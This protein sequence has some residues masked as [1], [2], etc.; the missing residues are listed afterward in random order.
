M[1]G[2]EEKRIPITCVWELTTKCNL[3]CGHCASSCNE[4]ER[5]E[6]LSEKEMLEVTR[7]IADMGL[8]WVSL[9]GGEVLL[10][11]GWNHVVKCLT[12]RNVRVH[13]IT[14]GTLITEQIAE[15]MKEANLHMVSV[16]L[17]GTKEIHNAIRGEGSY[18]KTCRKLSYVKECGI[19]LGCIT[20]V[21]KENL[22]LLSE[23]KEELIR[24]GIS[25]WQLQLAFPEGNMKVK[26]ESLLEPKDVRTFI[27]LAYELSLDNR[28]RIILPD[29]VGYY[30]WEEQNL[31]SDGTKG[32]TAWQGC[33]AGIRSFGILSN[34]DV[35]G[36]TS[37]RSA[38]FLEGNIRER[39][40]SDIWEDK[41]CF[42]WRRQFS[43]E[44]LQGVCRECRY[45]DICLGGCSNIR[46]T[47]NGTIYSEN[48]YCAYGVEVLSQ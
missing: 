24:I 40:L 12:E 1:R 4:Q 37:I 30:T 38:E 27:N 9:T 15:Q 26:K 8:R 22:S 3:R 21:M 29:N 35:V 42:N 19:T 33:S 14:N 47:V 44:C 41:K 17:D 11:K 23:M 46:Y 45:V 13:L 48:P 43:K 10:K 25:Q 18:E 39:R 16:S 31:R 36:C 5:Q 7:Q 6:E 28:I 34:G 32:K 20:S 2:A